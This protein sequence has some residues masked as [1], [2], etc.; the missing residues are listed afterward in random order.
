[1]FVVEV[2]AVDLLVGVDTK[3]EDGEAFRTPR[4]SLS[5]THESPD[6]GRTTHTVQGAGTP[7]NG[8]II[9]LEVVSVTASSAWSRD[10]TATSLPIA[11]AST[12]Q[13][14]TSSLTTKTISRILDTEAKTLVAA[15]GSILIE[16]Q[17]QTNPSI[18]KLTG[19]QRVEQEM[20]QATAA[21]TT[22]EATAE[23]CAKVG[24][25]WTVGEEKALVEE[26]C[27]AVVGT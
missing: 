17:D 22:E 7:M 21:I 12:K 10:T 1:M 27:T 4:S 13:T 14:T 24:V 26:E 6:G 8:P 23:I 18:V 11:V 19:M 15:A 2:E 20:Q 3:G 16:V 9:L 5:P 25:A